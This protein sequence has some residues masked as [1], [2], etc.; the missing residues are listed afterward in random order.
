V[1]R[2]S[3][4]DELTEGETSRE[5][6]RSSVGILSIGTLHLTELTSQLRLLSLQRPPLVFAFHS[7]GSDE[8]LAQIQSKSPRMSGLVLLVSSSDKEAIDELSSVNTDKLRIFIV[9]E[10]QDKG[11][12]FQQVERWMSSQGLA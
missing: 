6:N 1:D 4:L 8:A 11:A 10:T 3:S 7:K 12:A 9:N 5:N 2:G